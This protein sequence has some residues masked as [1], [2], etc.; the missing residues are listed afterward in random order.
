MDFKTAFL[1]GVLE[2]QVFVEQP[3]GYVVPG[4]EHRVLR[5]RRALY[6]L[7]Q[8]TRTWNT[9]LDTYLQVQG[10]TRCPHEYALYVKK[11]E[12][13]L[14]LICVYVD[15]LLITGSSSQQIAQFK[16]DLVSKFEMTDLGHMS[17]YLGLEVEQK[18]DGIFMSQKGY[19]QQV[20]TDIGLSH[21][22][23]V[24]TAIS[25]G[26]VFSS[27]SPGAQSTD[28]TVYRS[29]VGSFRYIMCTRP[30]IVY[31]VGMVSRYMQHPTVEHW[32]ACK[33]I[34]RYL[35]GTLDH[36]LWYPTTVATSVTVT[37]NEA[38]PTARYEGT[39]SN[40]N[41]VLYDPA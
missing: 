20:L 26:T 29:V 4:Q 10:F 33:R 25:M 12:Q 7:K 1:N 31:T 11:Q 15:D 16:R 21:C 17:H 19:I 40:G 14:I 23:A 32:M 36:G 6:G 9:T 22:K 38:V 30:D 39:D 28:A 34:L 3:L 37:T 18:D 5:L 24:N 35:K 27:Y 41:R 8:A 13:K 2:E